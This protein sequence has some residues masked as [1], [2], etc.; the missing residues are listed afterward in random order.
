MVT[1]TTRKIVAGIAGM[2]GTGGLGITIT[3]LAR[4]ASA[5]TVPVALWVVLASL[6]A[7]T[8]LLAGLGLV[9]GYFRARLEIAVRDRE[10]RATAELRAARLAMY[11][12]LVEKSAGEPGSAACYRALILADALHMA[13]EQNGV[14]PADRTHRGL[15]GI[16]AADPAKEGGDCG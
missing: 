16:H 8:V 6:L 11:R 10:A 9:L 15:Y 12:A 7:A 3:A 2:T 14:Q 1:T 4:Y 13:V 5:H